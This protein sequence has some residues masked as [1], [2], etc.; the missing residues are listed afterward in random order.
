L[1]T[2][3]RLP[4]LADPAAASQFLHYRQQRLMLQVQSKEG[5]HPLGFFLID[6]QSS[7]A[8][9]EVIA[10]HGHAAEPLALATGG[11]HL[12]AGAFGDDFALELGEGQ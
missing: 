4:A 8:G 11:G 7:A 10:E 5:T 12:V 2:V 6:V 3:A 9:I 1:T